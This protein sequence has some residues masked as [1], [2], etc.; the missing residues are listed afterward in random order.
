ML[1]LKLFLTII[2]KH[3]AK[4]SAKDSQTNREASHHE[5]ESTETR[6][7]RYYNYEAIN[8]SVAFIKLKF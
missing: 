1:D 8:V 7:F 5:W 4:H 3:N 6:D 2:F